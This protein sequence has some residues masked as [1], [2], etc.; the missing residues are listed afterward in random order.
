MPRRGKG[1]W[2]VSTR[3]R[4]RQPANR[5]C[6]GLASGEFLGEKLAVRRQTVTVFAGT[7]QNGGLIA[8]TATRQALH[9]MQRKFLYGALVLFH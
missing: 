3:D 5:E 1:D 8:D 9:D 7:L 4:S 6:S 2:I